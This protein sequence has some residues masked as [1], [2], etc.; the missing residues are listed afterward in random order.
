[1]TV[2]SFATYNLLDY[3][4]HRRKPE[5]A[6]REAALVE[7]IRNLDVDVL[8]VQEVIGDGPDAAANRLRE[9]AEAVGMNCVVA[10]NGYD[11]SEVA[12]AAAPTGY[13]VALLWRRG[14]TPVP[15]TWRPYHLPGDLWHAL[16]TVHLDL[17]GTTVKFASYHADP[18]RPDRRFVDAIRVTTAFRDGVPALLG[19]DFNNIGADPQPD[20]TFYDPDP[21]NDPNLLPDLA[22][23]PALLY[24]CVWDDD[25]A[26]RP[27]A[28]RRA[29][30]VL[31]RAGLHDAAAVLQARPWQQTTGHWTKI[32]PY[33]PRRIDAVRVTDSVRAALLSHQVI[34][35][36][37]PGP[38]GQPAVDPHT[39]SDHLPVKVTFD[40]AAI[41]A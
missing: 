8:A 32:D 7:V 25:P 17:G 35:S 10:D 30:A 36:L 9:L 39:A 3:G 27:L 16:A 21:F 41:S 4:K 28:D 5:T 19:G 29:S 6:A 24:Q 22:S 13:N 38:D 40:T 23:L 26:A 34:N 18:F 31:Y 11:Y 15:G 14:I 37:P 33:P 1:V 20:G 12:V 2:F